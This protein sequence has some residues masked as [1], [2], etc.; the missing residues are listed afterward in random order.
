[1]FYKRRANENYPSKVSN[2]SYGKCLKATKNIPSKTLVQIFKGPITSWRDI[3]EEHINYV[4]WVDDAKWI[5]P[6]TSARYINHSCDPNCI[7]DERLNVITTRPVQK[8]EELTITYNVIDGADP[9]L[10]DS[11]W[12]FQCKCGAQNCQGYINKYITGDGKPLITKL[13][14]NDF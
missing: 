14:T 5:I 11:R 10:W 8:G 1:M 7:V 12:S 6:L 9:G 3:T 2:C 4:L 13:K